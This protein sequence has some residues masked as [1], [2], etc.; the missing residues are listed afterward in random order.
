M[1]TFITSLALLATMTGAP[2]IQPVAAAGVSATA[3]Y[4][5][6]Q[7]MSYV[8]G[9]KRAVGYFEGRDGTCRVTLMIAEAVDPDIAPVTS[10]ARVRLSIQ[11]GQSADL[12]SAEGEA[13]QLICGT[14]ATTLQVTRSSAPRS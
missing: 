10:A 3:T 9:S 5:A 4:Q 1:S 2:A 8:L 12:G 6:T 11:P 13:M 14:D 7:A